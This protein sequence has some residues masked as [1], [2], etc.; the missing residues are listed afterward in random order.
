MNIDHIVSIFMVIVACYSVFIYASGIIINVLLKKRGV[1]KDYDY[2]PTVSVLLSCFNEG[3]AVYN[4]I[5]SLRMSNYPIQKL[6]ILAFDDCS[7]D[8]SFGWI[9]KAAEDFPNVIAKRNMHNQGKAHTVLDAASI[10]TG[11]IIVGVDSDCYFD[12]NA[13]RELMACFSE[14]NIA[15]VGGRVGVSNPNENWLTR[16][17]SVSYALSFLVIKSTE[18]IFR[19]IQC[20][21][22]PLVAIRRK[23]FEEVRPEIETRNFLG[24]RI[25]NGED[26]ALTQMLLRAGYDTYL[27]KDAV[28]WTTVPNKIG[29]YTKQQLR[30]RRSAIGQWIDA[31]IKLPKMV[32]SSGVISTSL[33][34]L[35]IF[36]MLSWNM[37]LIFSWLSGN[38]IAV[39]SKILLFHI[40]MASIIGFFFHEYSKSLPSEDYFGNKTSLFYSLII[41]SLWFPFSGFIITWFASFTLDDGGWVT[42]AQNTQ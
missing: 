2:E 26:R 19:K 14:P 27:N 12:P 13:I 1:R 23:C 10:A 3:E 18:N 41:A 31:V 17:Q 7:K 42:R 20:L 38:L 9:K 5:K 35:P 11:E 25:T 39:L 40:C 28:C 33:S 29:Q 15:A 21:S 8:D 34:L 37:L 22:G 32:F 24:I 30:W 6:E 16:F 4:T 36:V